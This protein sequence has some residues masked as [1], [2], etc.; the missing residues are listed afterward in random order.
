MRDLLI[1]NR[2]L[3]HPELPYAIIDWRHAPISRVFYLYREGDEYEEEFG[4]R[5]VEGE[6]LAHRKLM[7]VGGRLVRIDA[8]EG[9]FALD[10]G[11]WRELGR[12]RP[13][14]AGGAGSALRPAS[15]ERPGAGDGAPEDAPPRCWE[16]PRPIP[17]AWTGA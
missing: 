7:I 9:L 6:I 10:N 5:T 14:L 1:G 2:T 17:N 11:Q 4:G 3:A 8:P 16:W 12:E 13:T 15:L